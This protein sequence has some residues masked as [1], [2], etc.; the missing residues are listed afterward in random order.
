MTPTNQLLSPADRLSS[1]ANSPS[2]SSNPSPDTDDTESQKPN[3]VND[4]LNRYSTQIFQPFNQLVQAYPNMADEQAKAVNSALAVWLNTV[5]NKIKTSQ[6]QDT[7][8]Y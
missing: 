1:L 4:L 8:G 2:N 6:P 5:I 3:Q 7:G